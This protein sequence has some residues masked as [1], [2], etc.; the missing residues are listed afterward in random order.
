MEGG[1]AGLT[2]ACFLP[3]CP[4]LDDLFVFWTTLSCRGDFFA[5]FGLRTGLL[6]TAVAEYGLFSSGFRGLNV[7]LADG[8]AGVGLRLAGLSG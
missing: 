8:I 7:F 6:A 5:A 4:L 2:A 1:V 3:D